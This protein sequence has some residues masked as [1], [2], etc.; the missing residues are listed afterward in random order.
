MTKVFISRFFIF[1]LFSFILSTVSTFAQVDVEKMAKNFNIYLSFP[2]KHFQLKDGKYSSGTSPQ[3]FANVSIEK[4]VIKDLNGDGLDDAVLVTVGNYGGSGGFYELTA[5]LSTGSGLVQTNSIVLGDRIN[6]KKIQVHSPEAHSPPEL[7]LIKQNCEILIYL[8]KHKKNDPACC[9]TEPVMECFTI[10]KNKLIPCKEAPEP[11]VV[12]KPALYLYPIKNQEVEVEINPKGRVLKTIPGYREKWKVY[13]TKNGKINGKYNY[14]FYETTLDTPVPEYQRGWVVSYKELSRWFDET[15]TKFGLNK[16]EIR[17]FKA[18]WL[19]ELPQFPYYEIRPLDNQFL[20]ENLRLKIHPK[21]ETVIRVILHFK[22]TDTPS[23]LEEPAI[24]APVR[25]GF[26]AIE[27]GG[28]LENSPNSD[29]KPQAKYSFLA[30]DTGVV[31]LR[32]IDLR[33][34][35]LSIKLSSNGCTDKKALKSIVKKLEGIN[36][37]VPHYEITL[38]REKPD[39]CKALISEGTTIVYDLKEEFRINTKLPYT[40]T[41]KN[42]IYPLI[43]DE[44]YFQFFPKKELKPKPV[45]EDMSLKEHLIK[46][47]VRA[48]EMEIKR[49]ETSQQRDKEDKIDRLRNE[50]EKFNKMKPEDYILGYPNGA[51]SS[52]EMFT[53]GPL[54][55]PIHRQVEAIIEEPLK[56]GSILKLT[57]MTKSGPFYHI[58]GINE[59]IDIAKELKQG[60]YRMKL[61]LVYKREYFGFIQNYYVYIA[62]VEKQ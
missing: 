9:P 52:M 60:R 39:R 22:G 14:L 5:L 25:K 51:E 57:T 58:A 29:I 41:V 11:P 46:A 36:S 33:E 56:I 6:I 62:E 47:T 35:K 1:I 30:Q 55:P 42:P 8:L 23:K 59:N 34:H 10:H 17:D 31:I 12:K 7:G 28:I 44:P 21:P 2:E 15:L 18:Y 38:I 19:N 26:T 27:W 45:E 4:I 50:I 49:Y 16:R 37:Q 61:Y 24:I 43:T 32:A 3:D 13:V 48:I 40:V 53:Y 54:M 20:E